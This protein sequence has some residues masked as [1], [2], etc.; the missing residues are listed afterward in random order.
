[1]AVPLVVSGVGMYQFSPKTSERK[2]I[3]IESQGVSPDSLFR[4]WDIR[5]DM[6]SVLDGDAVMHLFLTVIPN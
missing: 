3:G 4:S 1:M 5:P 6:G 2:P